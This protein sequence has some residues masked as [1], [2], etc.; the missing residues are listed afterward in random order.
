MQKLVR[1]VLTSDSDILGNFRIIERFWYISWVWEICV[2]ANGRLFPSLWSLWWSVAW[3]AEWWSR[4]WWEI[5]CWCIIKCSILPWSCGIKSW[6]KLSRIAKLIINIIKFFF[7]IRK[8]TNIIIY[9]S[10]LFSP[11]LLPLYWSNTQMMY[12]STYRSPQ[13][14]CSFQIFNL[15]SENYWNYVFLPLSL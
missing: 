5:S 6:K 9:N 11:H 13:K 7:I 14:F 12:N 10:I 15:V 3:C 2:W 1:F 8:Y 4:Y